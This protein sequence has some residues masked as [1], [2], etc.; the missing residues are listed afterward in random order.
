MLGEL[1]TCAKRHGRL[2]RQ[3]GSDGAT[4]LDRQLDGAGASDL[5]PAGFGN[6]VRE[7]MERRR[8]TLV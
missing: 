1:Q 4:W 8:E 3:I 2:E 5:S 6:D 7:A